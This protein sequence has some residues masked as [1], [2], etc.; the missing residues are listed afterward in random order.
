MKKVI[1]LFFL[2]GSSYTT[3]SQTNKYSLEINPLI[4]YDHYKEFVGWETGVGGKHYVRPSG[5]SY[6]ID[7]NLKRQVDSMNSLYFGL[8]YYRHIISKI[9]SHSD[10]GKAKERLINFPSPLFISFYS[11][12]YAYNNLIANIGY[13]RQIKIQDSYLLTVGIDINN[14]FTF[15]Q[16][17]HL[18]YNPGGSQD[19]RKNNFR[20]FGILAGLDIGLIKRYKRFNIGPEIKLPIFSLLRTD[21]TFPNETGTGYRNQWFSSIGLEVSFTY[22]LKS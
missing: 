16:Y 8:G 2:I 15:S 14:L 21:S 22:K 17:Y 11:N 10:L 12:R 6:G 4:R 20:F 13:E 7:F 1:V 19:Y 3:F 18:S 5:I 9:E